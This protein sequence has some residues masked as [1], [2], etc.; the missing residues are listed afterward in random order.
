[1]VK[2]LIVL[3]A[4][5]GLIGLGLWWNGGGGSHP[6][7]PPLSV[8]DKRFLLDLA[9]RQLES[10]ITTGRGIEVRP[11]AVP[12][13]VKV[14]AACFVTL[15]EDGILR[16]CILD[17]F[18]PHEPMY[19]NVMRNVV[20]A[21]TSDP[22]FPPVR[23]AEL[24]KIEIEISVLDR[25]KP[26]SFSGPDDLLRK[27]HPGVDGV[28]LKTRTG[29]STYLPQVWE[30]FPDPVD[31]LSSLCEKQGADPNCWRSDPPPTVEI[32]HVIHFSESDLG[33]ER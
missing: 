17:S 13:D 32:Y 6:G 26:L 19:K 1:M 11:D 30:T 31:F 20:L 15:N 22:R 7:L 29:S 3:M 24:P 2:G 28:I 8:N 4:F 25:P 16:G 23:P 10:V 18:T 14:P 21:A 9:R 27:L 33:D 12:D 5:I